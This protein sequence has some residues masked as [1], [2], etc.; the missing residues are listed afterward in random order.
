MF[1]AG[2][3]RAEQHRD[4]FP[5][6]VGPWSTNASS[7]WNP[8][9]RLNVGAAC[10]FSECAVTS[11]ASKSMTSGCSA[12]IPWSGANRPARRHTTARAC[13]RTRSIAANTRGASTASRSITRD[14]VGSDATRPNTP[15]SVLSTAM[16]A[17]QS[18]P[19]AIATARS[20]STFPGSCTAS[21]RRHG[22]S[23]ADNA[24]S[25]PSVR[26]V[27]VSS[28]APAWDTTPDP[29]V[30]TVTRG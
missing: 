18:P 9:P 23:A 16:S 3:P 15:G 29:A 27:S 8:K 7:G 12:S 28:T 14:T 20:S 24:R 22:A 4:G 17:R 19:T 25:R 10:S 2:V 6:A 21:G 26:I 30:S 1:A 5:G 13:A 11:V